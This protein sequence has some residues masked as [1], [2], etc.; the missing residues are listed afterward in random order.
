MKLLDITK[1]F[2]MNVSE[3]CTVTGYS[4]QALHQ[5]LNKEHDCNPRRWN[6]AMKALKE[7]III[8]CLNDMHKAVNIK[9]SRLKELE[10]FRTM[11]VS[12]ES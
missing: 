1:K 6:A 8:D 11:G 7:S 3:F 2:G 5:I 9:N 10:T 4:R 12:Y